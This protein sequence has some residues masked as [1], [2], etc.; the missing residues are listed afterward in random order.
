MSEDYK[1]EINRLLSTEK[2]VF[3]GFLF[4]LSS[5]NFTS[6][7][8]EALKKSDDSKRKGRIFEIFCRDWLQSSESYDEVLLLS[9]IPSDLLSQLNMSQQDKG[10]DMIARK[11]TRFTAI[12]VKYRKPTKSRGTSSVT[13][14]QLSTFISLCQTT[15][16]FDRNIV[17][18]NLPRVSW[19][20][21][22]PDSFSVIGFLNFRNTERNYWMRMIGTFTEYKLS[23]EKNPEKEKVRSLREVHF[24]S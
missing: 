1:V 16:P 14:K 9:D 4:W 17:M 8:M 3:E 19:A 20:G 5:L 15:G 18:T 23:E 22:K 10:I 6:S 24:T 13:W 7:S 12:Q 2:N 11:G 21:R